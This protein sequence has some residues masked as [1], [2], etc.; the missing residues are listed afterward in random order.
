MKVS[1]LLDLRPGEVVTH[2]STGSRYTVVSPPVPS[3]VHGPRVEV[4]SGFGRSFITVGNADLWN[5]DA[6]YDRQ[7]HVQQDS[8][9]TNGRGKARGSTRRKNGAESKEIDNPLVTISRFRLSIAELIQLQ[10][11]LNSVRAFVRRRHD[12]EFERYKTNHDALE[13]K[14]MAIYKE[15]ESQF[16]ESIKPLFSQQNVELEAASHVGLVRSFFTSEKELARARAGRLAEEISKMHEAMWAEQRRR[17]EPIEKELKELQQSR[18]KDPCAG[19]WEHVHVSVLNK[20]IRRQGREFSLK[21]ILPVFDDDLNA[22]IELLIKH[23]KRKDRLAVLQVKAATSSVEARALAESVKKD[24][25]SQF[26]L[27]K[28]CPYCGGPLVLDT[29]HADHIY[30]VSKGGQSIKSNMVYV[31]IECNSKKRD[32]TLAQ[33]LMRMGFDR[34]AVEARLELLRKDF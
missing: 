25:F 29:A 15:V 19:W 11:E 4:R 17:I 31:C 34:S 6:E 32:N 20:T 7:Q 23:R 21:D 30:P 14:K 1:D 18:M 28:I 12:E 3:R 24:I 16:S 33:F 22:K 5:R 27:L 26:T 10:K 9:R 13:N 2:I 8:K